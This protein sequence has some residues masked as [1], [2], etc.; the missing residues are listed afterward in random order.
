[1][2]TDGKLTPEFKEKKAKDKDSE[3]ACC[4]IIHSMASFN[5]LYFY[6]KASLTLLSK[7]KTNKRV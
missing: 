6:H 7:L 2:E 1:M 5:L 3:M 4:S